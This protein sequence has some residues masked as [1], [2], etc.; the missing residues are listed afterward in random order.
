MQA[1]SAATDAGSN[2]APHLPKKDLAGKPRIVDGD[3]DESAT[4]DMRAYEF[5]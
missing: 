1:G 5:Q 4:I 3:G 2:S